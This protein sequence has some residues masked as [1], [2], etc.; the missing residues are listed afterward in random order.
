MLVLAGVAGVCGWVARGVAPFPEATAE[1]KRPQIVVAAPPAIQVVMRDA[2]CPPSPDPD[3][4]PEEEEVPE[5]AGEDVGAVIARAQLSAADH[6]AVFGI[7]TDAR[8]GEALAG[9]TVTISGGQM[10]GSETAITDEHG[11]YKIANLPAGYVRATF[12]YADY[13]LERG[14]IAISSLDPTPVY[15][16]IDPDAAPPAPRY[17][18]DYLET[19]PVPARTFES[20]LG[21]AAGEQGDELGVTFSSGTNIEN[22]YVIE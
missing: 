18:E 12:Y 8:S 5:S 1:P 7:V 6:N 10:Q 13:A 16:R 9:V 20:V 2:A 3:E 14:D 19:I 4:E 17:S 15:Q 21:A 11:A 22:T